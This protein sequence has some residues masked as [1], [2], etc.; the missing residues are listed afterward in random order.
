MSQYYT[1]S[2]TAKTPALIQMCL[3]HLLRPTNTSRENLVDALGLNTQSYRLDRAVNDLLESNL[4]LTD[5]VTFC[6]RHGAKVEE[7]M[8]DQ[9]AIDRIFHW[10]KAE[11]SLCLDEDITYTDPLTA[12]AMAIDPLIG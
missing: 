12:L 6:R 1:Q 2:Y 9:Y 8:T 3:D 10:L 11:L 5:L 4:A 7:I